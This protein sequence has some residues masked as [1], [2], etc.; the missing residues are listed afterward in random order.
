METYTDHIPTWNALAT[1]HEFSKMSVL[2]YGCGAGTRHLCSLF[3]KCH[4]VELYH[5]SF[6]TRKWFDELTVQ[7]HDVPNWDGRAVE[8]VSDICEI[9]NE[10][11]NLHV[12]KERPYDANIS[13]ILSQIVE[14]DI[15]KYKPNVIFIDP[16]IHLR[17]EIGKL[18]MDN[19]WADMVVVHDYNWPDARYGYHLLK[20]PT[21]YALTIPVPGGT[22]TAVFTFHKPILTGG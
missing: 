5:P 8:V 18:I 2:E 17:G 3:Q 20:A 6:L 1:T 16:G 13:A 11:R 9:E 21:D 10:I 22:G 15:R 7:L 4:S 12:Y 19:H 14:E